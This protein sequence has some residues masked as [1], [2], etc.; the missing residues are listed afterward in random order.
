MLCKLNETEVLRPGLNVQGSSRVLFAVIQ[1]GS[2]FTAVV[3]SQVSGSVVDEN[4]KA[5]C[6]CAQ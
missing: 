5:A 4:Q 3:S 1:Q 2:G 6:M